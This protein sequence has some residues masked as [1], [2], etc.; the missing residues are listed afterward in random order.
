[1]CVAFI[2]QYSGFGKSLT[3][4][5]CQFFT[6]FHLSRLCTP[7]ALVTPVAHSNAAFLHRMKRKHIKNAT[8][9]ADADVPAPLAAYGTAEHARIGHVSCKVQLSDSNLQLQANSS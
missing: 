8:S 3:A 5:S 9:D 2:T 1:V 7:I 6:V 4:E